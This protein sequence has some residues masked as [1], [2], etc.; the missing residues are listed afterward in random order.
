METPISWLFDGEDVLEG[1]AI[2]LSDVLCN[3]PFYVLWVARREGL[4]ERRQFGESGVGGHSGHVGC[5]RAYRI[6]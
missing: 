2:G 1:L 6:G 4:D 5:R 3:H